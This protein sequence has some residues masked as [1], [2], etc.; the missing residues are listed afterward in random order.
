MVP[1][2]HQNGDITGYRIQYE[3]VGGTQAT[4]SVSGGDVTEVAITGLAQSTY[5]YVQVAAVNDV[6]TGVFS[7]I[8]LVL[9]QGNIL[10]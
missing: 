10:V 5:Y 1:C 7:R 9:T 4:V 2:I 8:V 3:A 6:G